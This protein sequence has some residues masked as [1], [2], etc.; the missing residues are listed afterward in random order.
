VNE[1]DRQGSMSSSPRTNPGEETITVQIEEND[2][3][4]GLLEF[5]QTEITVDET[6][7][8][9][10]KHKSI[11]TIVCTASTESASDIYTVIGICNRMV[12]CS[13]AVAS[14]RKILLY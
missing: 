2:N 7:G 4:R 14:L 3:S 6:V 11:C 13:A 1:E 9:T 10:C 12:C 5:V 8:S